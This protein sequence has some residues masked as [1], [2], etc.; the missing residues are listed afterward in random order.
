MDLRHIPAIDQHA[1]NLLRREIAAQTP[2]VA[3]FTEGRDPVILD[4]HA[5]HTLFYRRSLRDIGELLGCGPGEVDIL[6]RRDEL[7][8]EQLTRI[9]F[10]AAKLEAILLDDGFLPDQVLPLAWHERFVRVHRLLRLEWLAEELLGSAD[11]FEALLDQFR[12]ALDPPPGNVVGLKS[13]AA[14][15]TGLD[16]Q[17]VTVESAA[18]AWC[19]WKQVTG[20][21]RPR[22]ANKHLLDFLLGQ[23]MEL[24]VKHRLPVQ[25]HTGFGDTDLDLRLANP[26]HLRGLLEDERFRSVSVVLLHAA[27]P[28][29]QEVGY[30]A[31]VYPQVYLD[32]GLS[33]PFLS[34]SGMRT[35]LRMLLELAPFSKLM[36]A[37]DAHLVPELFYLGAKWGRQVLGACLEGAISDG[38]LTPDEA[39]E[40]AVA[41]LQ[42]NARRLYR[43]GTS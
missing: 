5:R 23:A 39:D 18:H 2:F 29:S 38:D 40:V 42:G 15:R 16:I 17:P 21:R 8:L 31:S 20:D 9:C 14:Y 43:L 25:F 19:E 7:G 26:L 35:V 33:V 28:F 4:E 3:P 32:M 10:D 11:T 22:L 30:L 34:V 24:A 1:H 36:Y 12:S 41:V 27:Y 13:I 37:S 6:A